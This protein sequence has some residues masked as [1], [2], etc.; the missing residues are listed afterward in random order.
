VP[1]FCAAAS[2]RAAARASAMTMR[3][4]SVLFG[5]TTSLARTA[6]V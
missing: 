5:I 2:G 6:R 4:M 3:P 1:A